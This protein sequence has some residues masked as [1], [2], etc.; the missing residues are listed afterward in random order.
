V[1]VAALN[2][3]PG[4]RCAMPEGAF[5]A[6]P[7]ITGTG[8]KSKALADALLERAGVACLSGTAFGA[9]GEGYVRFSYANSTENLMEA[10]G[11]IERFL[12]G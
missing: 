7:N 1:F 4:L 3:V 2:Q 10:V 8:W 9:Y 12:R 5:Y 11:R 6:F